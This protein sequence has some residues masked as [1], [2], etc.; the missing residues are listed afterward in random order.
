M[1]RNLFKLL[2]IV[3]FGIITLHISASK[4]YANTIP[5]KLF[6]KS[7]NYLDVKISLNGGYL[8]T[9]IKSKGRIALVIFDR[10]NKKMLSS[11]RFTD[12]S[13]KLTFNAGTLAD[14]T[15]KS[16]FIH[17]RQDTV[18][19]YQLN[20]QNGDYQKIYAKKDIDVTNV[21]LNITS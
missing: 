2:L 18:G 20:I 19:L 4:V 1:T 7:A 14:G 12:Q 5:I 15:K 11:T 13:G 3:A 17:R 8:A 6:A 10:S 9:R 16:I 21:Q